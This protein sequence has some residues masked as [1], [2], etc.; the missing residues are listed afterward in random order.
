MRRELIQRLSVVLHGKLGSYPRDAVREDGA[1][2]VA[3]LLATRT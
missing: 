3:R 2:V 1:A